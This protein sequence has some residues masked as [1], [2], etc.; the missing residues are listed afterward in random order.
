MVQMTDVK[1]SIPVIAI[2]DPGMTRHQIMSAFQT[3]IEFQL[4]TVIDRV[5]NAAREI[6]AT[7]AEIIIIDHLVAD[8]PTLDL[9]DDL[10]TQFPERAVIALLP[11]GDANLAQQV[12][13]AGARAFLVQPFTQADFLSTLRRVRALEERRQMVKPPVTIGEASSSEP[14]QIISIFSPRGGVGC[15]TVAIN[16]AVALHE[17]I[18]GRTLLMEGK[19]HFG[20]LGLMLNIRPRN[21]L[22]ELIP[23][24]N[25]L[26]AALI[27]DVVVQ[28]ATGIEVLLSPP[29]IE[30][31]QGIKPDD[32]LNVLRG[33]RPLYDFIVIDAGSYLNENTVT[34]MDMSDRVLLVANPDLASLHDVSRFIQV[35]RTL[36]YPPG[37]VLV[38]LNRSGMLG[39]VKTKD[40]EA[41]LHQSPFAEIPE[42]GT[43][44]IRSLNRGVPMYFKY[45]RNPVSRSIRHLAKTLADI[46]V[47]EKDKS[48]KSAAPSILPKLRDRY[49]PYQA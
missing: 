22:A 43:K 8:L 1:T 9:V 27:E 18:E 45:P 20:H 10:C 47:E 30:M 41:A 44:A 29:N 37:K 2:I 26:D 6:R 3:Q 49:S 15:S 4:V 28:H 35:S 23:H 16:L 46:G 11:E 39:G 48:R 5:E 12:M 34:L 40:I 32:V 13:F 36:G 25:S 31:A 42:D 19:L 21:S 7:Q 24:A 14:L 17:Q 38:I 33:V